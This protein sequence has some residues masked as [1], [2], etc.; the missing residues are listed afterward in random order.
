MKQ[1]STLTHTRPELRQQLRVVVHAVLPRE[2][3]VVFDY[4][5]RLENNP[6]W[7]WSVTSV[8]A[9]TDGAPRQGSLYLQ[10]SAGGEGSTLEL[11]Q[12]EPPHL[13]EVRSTGVDSSA[14]YRYHLSSATSDTTL[15]SLQ[16][17]VEPSHPV[18]LTKLYLQRLRAAL[19]SNLDG[20]RETLIDRENR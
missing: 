16:V 5:T 14:T 12:I 1:N 10:G 2:P 19:R 4:L 6:E 7:N 8:L 9:L 17:A 20:L 15:V 3:E 18:G 13:L 11:T